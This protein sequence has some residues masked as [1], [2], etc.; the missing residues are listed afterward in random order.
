MEAFTKNGFLG[1]FNVAVDD[2]TQKKI[3]GFRK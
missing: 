1:K 2:T 3:Y